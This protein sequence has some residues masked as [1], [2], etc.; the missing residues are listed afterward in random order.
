[1]GGGA[2]TYQLA[3]I[4]V[5]DSDGRP[6]EH[7]IVIGATDRIQ[8]A[9]K[10]DKGMEEAIEAGGAEAETYLGYIAFLGA[11]RIKVGDLS[12]DFDRWLEGFLG[13][14]MVVPGGSETDVAEWLAKW[15]EQ[16]PADAVAELESLIAAEDEDE[17]LPGETTP[18]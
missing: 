13:I 7:R 14:D 18:A 16:V 6:H 17:E 5:L 2:S 4:A 11:K 8:A 9:R 12:G 1:M 10:F 3:D 15:R